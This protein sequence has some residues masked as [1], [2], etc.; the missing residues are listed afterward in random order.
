METATLI[1]I[2]LAVFAAFFIAVFQYTYQNKEES[3]LKYLLSSLRFI[4][5]F[6]IFI[7]IIN[8]SLNKNK[9]EIIKPNL[10]V[11][12][13]NSTSIKYSSQ[14]STVQN[15]VNLFK[16]NKE[17]NNKYLV[18]YYAL[19]SSLS[20]LDSLSFSEH[21][22]NLSLPFKEFDKLFDPSVAPLVFISDG[23]QTIGNNVEFVNYKS[24]VFPFIVGDTM[25]LE[26]IKISQLNINKFAQ[27]K[28]KFPVEIF[29]NYTGKK[30]VSKRLTIYHRNKIIFNQVYDFSSSENVTIASPMLLSDTEGIQYYTASIEELNNEKNT[31][32]NTKNFS[33]NVVEEKLKI[34]I[35]SSII[36]PDLGM[37]KKSIESNQQRSVT[38]SNVT[39]FNGDFKNY[40]LVILYQPTENFKTIF[41]EIDKS[42][43]NYFIVSGVQTDWNFLNSLKLNFS[44]RITTQTE[45]YFP[46]YNPNYASYLN[47]DIGFSDFAPL[48]D[49]FGEVS[50]SSPINILLYKRIGTIETEKPLLVTI[51]NS[52]QRAAIL[53]GENSWRW[54]MNSFNSTKTFENFDNFISNLIQ[55]LTSIQKNKR[56]KANVNHIY[57]ANE[58]IQISASYLDDNFNFNTRAKLFLT[59]S[60]TA[61]N[62]IKKVP[63]SVH[64]NRFFVELS[65]IPPGEYSYIIDVENQNLNLKGNFKI[66]SFEVE[67]QFSNSNDIAL[68]SISSKTNG[69]IYYAN[70]EQDLLSKLINDQR[71]KSIQ[72][73]KIIKTPLI[74]WKWLLGIIILS[75]SLEWFLRKYFG[76]I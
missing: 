16:K 41:T 45:S 35:L 31:I 52:N 48:E 56:L 34:L 11:V 18:S 58:I 60:N 14:D 65:E 55:Y 67:Q 61:D 69:A 13:D 3:K 38:I 72:Q 5:L 27:I 23:N 49:G 30:Q 36:H 66:L 76:K 6:L 21:Q 59:I 50:F 25:V 46:I 12:V 24:P 42:K 71:F 51:E 47:N 7:L 33:I 43:L 10:V 2:I 26:D 44:K 19:G 29:I 68:K 28:N 37:L 73:S 40:Q 1:F 20:T 53:L 9:I 32:N 64:N 74:H 57:F 8:P 63:F 22:T 75:L 62:F 54:R 15:L 70:Q 39:D 4:S 17:L